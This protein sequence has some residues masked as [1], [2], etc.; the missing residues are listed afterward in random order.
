M[1]LPTLFSIVKRKDLTPMTPMTR[2][3][4][5]PPM[6]RKWIYY[7]RGIVYRIRMN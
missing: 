2:D 3:P 5:D 7:Q 6:T 1:F 4:D